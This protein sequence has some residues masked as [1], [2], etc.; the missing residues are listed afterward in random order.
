MSS[1]S[2][3]EIYSK[4][5]EVYIKTLVTQK[6][7]NE[8]ENPLE[9]KIYVYKI[10]GSIFSSFSAKIGD[11]IEVKSKVI[12]S[13]NA[14]EKYTDSISSGNAAIFVSKDPYNY[15]RIIINMGNI[16]P[17]QEVIFKSE[18]IQYIESSTS[19]EFELFRNLPIFSG[20]DSVFQNSEI[21]GTV[22]INTKYIINKIEKKLLSDKLNIVEE[23]Y[24]NEN[25]CEY[26]MKYEYKNLSDLSLYNSD[27][28]IPSNK[29]CFEIE[30]DGPISF[31]QKSSKENE[32]NYIIQYKFNNKE[33]NKENSNILNPSLFI[34]L[35]DQSGSMSGQPMEVASKAMILFLQSLPAGSYY[36]IIGFG[37]NYE[38]YDKEPKEWY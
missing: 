27:S 22:E 38:K 1:N 8:S 15:N 23:K 30:K 29:I 2:S 37:S 19:Y 36:Q 25:K 9:L 3:V 17:K 10:K 7:K 35:I 6:L 20:K 13:K 26:L 12:K 34:F 24:L 31:Y 33:L 32:I 14:E 11:S 16:P 21:K 4:V 28:Y 18:F 5:N